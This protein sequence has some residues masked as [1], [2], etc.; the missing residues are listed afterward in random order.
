MGLERSSRVCS[1]LSCPYH[2]E[3]HFEAGVHSLGGETETKCTRTYIHTLD[4]S[5]PKTQE[6]LI[7]AIFMGHIFARSSGDL[8]SLCVLVGSGPKDL[9]G[10]KLIKWVLVESTNQ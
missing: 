3:H 1:A 8:K 2:A 7:G 4:T 6:L 10:S 9:V 5:T